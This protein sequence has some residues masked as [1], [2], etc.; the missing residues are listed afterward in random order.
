[1]PEALS[2]MPSSELWRVRLCFSCVCVCVCICVCACACVCVCG[3]FNPAYSTLCKSVILCKHIYVY[4]CYVYVKMF[5]KHH[6]TLS[7]Q[8]IYDIILILYIIITGDSI[9]VIFHGTFVR[10]VQTWGGGA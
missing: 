1:M 3:L 10:N 2:V 7:L 4:V 6:R 9:S 8:I 5:L